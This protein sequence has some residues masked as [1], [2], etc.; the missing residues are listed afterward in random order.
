MNTLLSTLLTIIILLTASQIH[1]SIAKL[2]QTAQDE[3][4]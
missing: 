2:I 3:N 1:Y 4:V